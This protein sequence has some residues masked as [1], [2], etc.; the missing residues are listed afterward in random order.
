MH[1]KRH[2]MQAGVGP[3]GVFSGK[4]RER[5]VYPVVRNAILASE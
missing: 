1:L 5:Q 3:Y 4:R 2:R